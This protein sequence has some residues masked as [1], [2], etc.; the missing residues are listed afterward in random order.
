MCLCFV[1]AAAM[2]RH[3]DFENARGIVAATA[4]RVIAGSSAV[5][6]RHWQTW[7][8][9]PTTEAKE[10]VQRRLREGS[11]GS[12]GRHLF[13]RHVPDCS[14]L[15]QTLRIV[16]REPTRSQLRIPTWMIPKN[17][18]TGTDSVKLISSRRE[19]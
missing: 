5:T 8:A 11:D 12:A 17:V 10:P 4:A 6:L 16:G 3:A 9:T 13:H 14:P 19:N 7:D 2:R 15:R 18:A 1:S